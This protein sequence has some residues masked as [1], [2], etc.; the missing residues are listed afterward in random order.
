MPDLDLTS[1]NGHVV[2]PEKQDDL[3]DRL[4]ERNRAGA[5]LNQLAVEFQMPP[6][7]RQQT[8]LPAGFEAVTWESAFARRHICPSSVLSMP[9]K[10]AE[11]VPLRH[12]PALPASLR[13]AA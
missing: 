2:R 9:S 6:I 5:T 8:L 1:A 7:R 10:R 11:W 3:V 13:C 4:A 12:P